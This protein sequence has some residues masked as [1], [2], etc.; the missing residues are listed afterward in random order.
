MLAVL[1]AFYAGAQTTELTT[2]QARSLYKTTTKKRTGVHDPSIVWEPNSKRYYIFGSHKAGAYT[3]DLKNWT[4]AAPTWSPNDNAKAFVTPAVKKVKKDGVE[5]DL[6]Q[7]NA[8]AWSAKGS[9]S[10]DI[11]GNMWAPDVLWNEKMQKWCMYLSINGDSWFSSIIL[12]TSNNIAGPYLYQGPVVISGFSKGTDYK[13]TDLE[14]VLGKLSSLPSRYNCYWGRRYPNNIDPC[15][16]YDEEG[17]LRMVYGSWSGG[18]WMLELDEET[19]LRDYDVKYTQVGSDDNITTDPYFG[20][21]VAGGYYAS[22][23]APYIEYINGYYY[24]FVTNGGLQAGGK[25]DDIN[26]GGYQM[27]VF[28]SKNPDGPYTDA[29]GQTA[30]LSN[31]E[32]NFGPNSNTRGENILGAYGEWGNVVKGDYSE[33]AQGHNSIIAAPDGRTYLVYHTRFQNRGEGFEARVH[34]VFQ[35]KQ[36][37]LVAAPFEYNG[38]E[39]T[40]ADIATKELVTDADIPGTYQL[41]I[42]KYKLDHRQKDL[43]TP[44]EITLTADGK[45]SGAYPGTWSHEA[46]TSYF[47]LNLGTIAVTYNGVIFEEETDGIST[48]AVAFTAMANNG[49]NV[50]GYKLAPK[51]ALAWQLNNQKAPIYNNKSI[52]E[53]ADLDA[54]WLGDPSVNMQWTSDQ[55]AIISEHGR[56]NPTGLTEDTNVNLAVKLSAGDYYWQQQYTVKALSEAASLPTAEW[57][58]G[59]VAHYGFDDADLAN[60]FDATQKAQLK[61]NGTAKVP[62]VESND[63]L[64]NGSIIHLS[65]GNNGKESYVAMPNPLR[66]AT[67]DNGATISFWVNRTV[68][69]LWDALLGITDGTAKFFVTG[70]AYIGYNNG[71]STNWIDINNPNDTKTGYIPVGNWHFVTIVIKSSGITLY[72]D[73]SSKSAKKVSGKLNGTDIPSAARFDYSLVFNLLTTASD[74]CLG[75]GSYWGSPDSR[76]DDVFIHDRALTISEVSA[77]K[78]VANRVIDYGKVATGISEIVNSPLD[79]KRRFA[80]EEQSTSNCQL[81]DLQ[82]RRVTNPQRGL[83]IVNGKKVVIK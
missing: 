79:A 34:Q 64:R 10:Y 53:N 21:K 70:N 31:Y 74:L 24:L 12:L 63:N 46:G 83:Y 69:D 45:V 5:V 55:P 16:F 58:K 57:Q 27:R 56:Y 81:Y 38:E 19:G 4:W 37:W 39:V 75:N 22:G 6:P 26:Y 40:S 71:N 42:H 44:V 47:T 28:R 61:K 68:D 15:V 48:H 20:K 32:M 82:G 14:L 49:V 59:L 7:F 62:T 9:S 52:D 36:G 54:L 76:L 11:N 18:I 30:V 50:W 65:A 80:C 29:S 72:V 67:L 17:K 60:T 73:G 43:V 3:T 23:E 66:G 78:K 41:L 1:P 77:L 8:M 35:N 2:A 33:R 25:S 13:E 51:Y